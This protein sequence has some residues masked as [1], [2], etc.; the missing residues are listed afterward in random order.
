MGNRQHIVMYKTSATTTTRTG[1]KHSTYLD[2]LPL[3]FIFST[4]PFVVQSHRLYTKKKIKTI[5]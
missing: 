1:E 5:C 4:A 2:S 3:M